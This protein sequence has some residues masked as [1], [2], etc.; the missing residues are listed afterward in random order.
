[1][2][3]VKQILS[4][5]VASLMLTTS[6]G[7]AEVK[8][9]VQNDMP[10]AEEMMNQ[11]LARQSVGLKIKSIRGVA[12]KDGDGSGDVRNPM[13]PKV[14]HADEI[15][16]RYENGQV[17]NIG[18]EE[19]EVEDGYKVEIFAQLFSEEQNNTRNDIIVPQDDNLFPAYIKLSKAGEDSSY[20]Q[21]LCTTVSAAPKIKT[22][23][24]KK[25]FEA[26]NNRKKDSSNEGEPF[27][28][29]VH[30]PKEAEIIRVVD[31]KFEEDEIYAANFFKVDEKV[32]DSNN[33]KEVPITKPS[34]KISFIARNQ[35]SDYF[36]YE[37]Q[38]TKDMVQGD[39]SNQPDG[40]NQPDA[41]KPPAQ[42]PA[43]KKDDL[44]KKDS[45][46]RGNGGGGGGGS[47][48]GSSSASTAKSNDG[49][50]D[51]QTTPVK[52]ENEKVALAEQKAVSVSTKLTI[53]EKKYT[54]ITDGVPMEKMMDVSPMIHQGRTML[55][56]RMIAEVLGIDVNFDAAT[57][58]AHFMYGENKVELTL[59]Q[60]QM[61]VNGE[62][63]ELTADIVNQNGRI[64]LP[65]R[66]IQTAFEKMGLKAMI[67]WDAPSK[68]VTIEK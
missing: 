10:M 50:K 51:K 30:L 32:D 42:N 15:V 37:V 7:F 47:F 11:D 13:N 21:V 63:I 44:P 12:V 43:P 55:P 29:S 35:R 23:L 56:A 24:G 52:I 1:M 66:D 19:I 38:V 22:I 36:F 62:K 25:P 65:L 59:G 9:V 60:K 46:P 41:P 34:T 45:A 28:L 3:R 4:F 61:M 6:L 8:P 27:Q 2:K 18:I 26:D 54:V 5:G 67:Q 68:T 39:N 48:S 17:A 40:N 64:L 14:I 20:Y 49:K 58:T 33:L 57:K 16:K 53:G 31:I